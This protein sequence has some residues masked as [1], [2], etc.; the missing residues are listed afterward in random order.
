MGQVPLV[1]QADIPA[2]P[3]SSDR[4]LFTK[5]LPAFSDARGDQFEPLHVGRQAVLL[6]LRY[7]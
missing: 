2:L 4:E 1:L 5:N 7:Q 3:A 6:P